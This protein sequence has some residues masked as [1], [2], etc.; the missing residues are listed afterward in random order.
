MVLGYHVIRSAYGFWL[1]NDPRGSGSFLVRGERL[2]EFGPGTK[3]PAHEFCAH[4]PHDR[5]KRRAA[6]AALDHAPVRF[7]GEQARAVAVGFANCVRRSRVTIWACAVLPDHV[8][9]VVA[10]HRHGIEVLANLLKGE[11]TRELEREGIH[12][13][14][15]Q[16]GYKG[17][18]P[19]CF[20]RKWWIIYKDNDE[21]LEN[22]IRYV[23]Q[24]PIKAG[25]RPQSDWSCVTKYP[26]WYVPEEEKGD[27]EGQ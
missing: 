19:S 11:A 4:K 25:L 1:P 27:K 12:P 2:R 15:G 13:F 20:G 9:L 14:R 21:A 7:T 23:E 5:A 16:V 3:V 8:H 26:N 17:R 10:R 24:N 18:V 6:K 22:A